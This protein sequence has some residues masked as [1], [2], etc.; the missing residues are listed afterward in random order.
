VKKIFK[1]DDKFLMSP[2]F[3]LF[4]AKT[5][6]AAKMIA[7]KENDGLNGELFQTNKTNIVE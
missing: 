6:F 4:V 3:D 2:P 7:L 5:C 1:F